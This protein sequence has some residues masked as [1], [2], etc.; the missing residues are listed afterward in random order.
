MDKKDN[1]IYFKY[2]KFTPFV[3]RMKK[4]GLFLLAGFVALGIFIASNVIV[5][6][7]EANQ[8]EQISDKVISYLETDGEFLEQIG[9]D[10]IVKTEPYVSISRK[11]NKITGA[12]CK[13]MVFVN[14]KSLWVTCSLD[15]ELNIT[16]VVI[17]PAE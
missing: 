10:F 7:T 4:W 16:N 3:Y 5:Y 8:S 15:S 14:N 12:S 13:V 6:V 2:G 1:I 11:G 9:G 17:N